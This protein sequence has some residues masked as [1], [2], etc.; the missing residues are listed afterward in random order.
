MLRVLDQVQGFLSNTTVSIVVY[1]FI[2]LTATCFGRTTILRGFHRNTVSI[3]VRPSS[4][5]NIYIYIQLLKQCSVR[6][7]LLNLI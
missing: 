6:R 1:Y 7:E 5:G 4:S 2:Q 3:V